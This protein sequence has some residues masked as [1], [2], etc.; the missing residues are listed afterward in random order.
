MFLMAGVCAGNVFSA[1]MPLAVDESRGANT[2]ALPGCPDLDP[3]PDG[4]TTPALIISAINPGESIE[5]FNDGGSSVDLSASAG[6]LCSPFTY[7]TLATLAPE[8]TIRPGEYATLP[9]P[10]AFFDNEAGG[11]IILYNISTSHLP[12]NIADFIC[13][14]TGSTGRKSQAE[15]VGKWSGDCVA[16]IASGKTIRRLT[17]TDGATLASYDASAEP[18]S[19]AAPANNIFQ[20]GFE[21]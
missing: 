15:G 6:D 2:A 13:W 11:Q 20:N 5:L 8:T 17:G 18:M 10:A 12:G 9:W 14:G 3:Q 7:I 19:C 4:G 16:A 21:D 1:G